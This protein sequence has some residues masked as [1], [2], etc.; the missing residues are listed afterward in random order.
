[1]P[2]STR[3]TYDENEY[4]MTFMSIHPYLTYAETDYDKK[5]LSIQYNLLERYR[6]KEITEDEVKETYEKIIKKENDKTS[7]IENLKSQHNKII[8]DLTNVLNADLL[9]FLNFID[10]MDIIETAE[11]INT[12]VI[13]Q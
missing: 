8:E 7:L 11:S 6:N 2:F 5:K 3:E 4:F 1:M 13:T 12:S 9:N 10:E